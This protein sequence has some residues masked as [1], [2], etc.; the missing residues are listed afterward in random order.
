MTTIVDI[1]RQKVKSV[2][3]I[4]VSLIFSN[5][6]ISFLLRIAYKYVNILQICS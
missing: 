5:N 1:R 3:K 6:N 4:Q 2:K